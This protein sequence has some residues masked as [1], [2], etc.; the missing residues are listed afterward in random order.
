MVYT[1]W[2]L[3][4][5]AKHNK[6]TSIERSKQLHPSNSINP[7]NEPPSL[8]VG[9]AKEEI[10]AAGDGKPWIMNNGLLA[11]YA[12]LGK[13]Q[14][15]R[16]NRILAN[17]SEPLGHIHRRKYT[18]LFKDDDTLLVLDTAEALPTEYT[19]TDIESIE[20]NEVYAIYECEGIYH[21]GGTVHRV[22]LTTDY[23][24]KPIRTES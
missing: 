19:L 4:I 7:S 24:P 16:S 12:Y 20:A 6:Q 2:R 23:P 11:A 1:I 13:V 14:L 3:T 17:T 5:T 8:P 18:I 21:Q 9:I 10:K 22:A 15:G